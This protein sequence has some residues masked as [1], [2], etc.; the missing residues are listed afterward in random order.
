MSELEKRESK[1]IILH[2]NDCIASIPPA[3]TALNEYVRVPYAAILSLPLGSTRLYMSVAIPSIVAILLVSLVSGAISSSLIF[4][5]QGRSFVANDE[6]DQANEN[7]DSPITQKDGELSQLNQ[8]LSQLKAQNDEAG[9]KISHLEIALADLSLRIEKLEKNN[10][11]LKSKLESIRPKYEVIKNQYS[12]LKTNYKEALESN[13]QLEEEIAYYQGRAALQSSSIALLENEL[14]ESISPPYTFIKNR[15]IYWVFKDS[16]GSEYTWNMPIDTYRALIER[17]EPQNEKIL[18]SDQGIEYAVRDHTKFVDS[19]SFSPWVDHVF[20]KVSFDNDLNASSSNSQFVYEL[21][22]IVSQLTA[23]SP[24][25]GEDP[26]WPL[27]TLV[28]GGGDCEDFAILMASLLK[29]SSHTRDWHIQ[30][31]YFDIENRSNPKSVNHVSLVV[32]NDEFETFLDRSLDPSKKETWE[33]V[34][35]WYFDL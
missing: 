35:G 34:D 29:A 14:S 24:D 15:E 20:E 2:G 31:V 33:N 5:H 23:Y 16:Q 19:S 6:N 1:R 4:S 30:M 11:N 17:P 22:Y 26:R 18:R 12:E 25:I 28:E 7:V 10:S 3:P 27:E 9:G 13:S 21:W 32:K 8:Q